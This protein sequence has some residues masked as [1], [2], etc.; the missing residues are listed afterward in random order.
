VAQNVAFNRGCLAAPANRA[1]TVGLVN[2]DSG[3]PHNFSIYTD[4]TATVALYTG[5]IFVGPATRRFAVK[6]LRPGTYYFR[7]DVHP[8]TMT[9]VLIVR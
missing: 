4:A 3:V 8:D 6:A 1:F 7:C 2:Q 5:V 9:G